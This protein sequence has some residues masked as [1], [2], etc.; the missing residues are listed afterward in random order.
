MVRLCRLAAFVVF[1]GAASLFAQAPAAPVTPPSTTASDKRLIDLLTAWEKKM[2]GME[3]LVTKCSRNE[4][5][6]LNGQKKTFEGRALFARPNYA[7]LVMADEKASTWEKYVSNGVNL[8]EYLP[9]SRSI[10]VHELPKQGLG[11]NTALS[12]LFGMK[13]ED[14]RKRYTLTLHKEDESYAYVMIY[15]K[16]DGD[17]QEF[18][19]AQLVL[20]TKGPSEMMPCRLWFEAPNGDEA[21]WTFTNPTMNI[22]MEKKELMKEFEFPGVPKDWTLQKAAVALPDKDKEMP[23]PKKGLPEVPP[24]KARP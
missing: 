4:I 12:F 22:R 6:K 11:D 1:T 21:T 3:T 2:L 16:Y 24:L 19:R 14:A 8:Y 17:K 15:P 9:R 13:V 23:L 5:E 7:Q 18:K 20:F 10:R